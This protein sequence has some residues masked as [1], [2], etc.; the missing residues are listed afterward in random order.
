MIGKNVWLPPF[1]DA[2]KSGRSI[3]VGF[4]GPDRRFNNEYAYL[5]REHF[6]IATKL[7]HMIEN[8]ISKDESLFKLLP[9][10]TYVG[11]I[12]DVQLNVKTRFLPLENLTLG[13]MNS[14]IDPRQTQEW[15]EKY[16]P[17]IVISDNGIQIYEF[18]FYKRFLVSTN[19]MGL[20]IRRLGELTKSAA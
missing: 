3:R 11:M 2:T 12:G 19:D 6:S 14:A 20:F 10:Y 15:Y 16:G 17:H 8:K 18:E 1:K 9:Q 5:G 4:R 13:P 7:L